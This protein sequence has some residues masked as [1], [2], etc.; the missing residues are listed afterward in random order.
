VAL[1]RWKDLCID[2][3]DAGVLAVFWG[4]VLG[5]RA[6]RQESGDFVLLGDAPEQTVWVNRVPEPKSVKNRVHLDLV[7][8]D[9]SS[10]LD[11]GAVELQRVQH[12]PHRWTVLADPEGGEFCVFDGSQGEPSALVVDSPQPVE[13]ARWWAE[14]LDAHLTPGPEGSLRWLADVAGLP[15][16]VVKF[17]G[18][19]DP[20]RVKNRVHWDVTCG[21]VEALVARGARVLREPDDEVAWH[22]LADPDGNEFCAFA[23]PTG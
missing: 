20:R 13:S 5:L 2:A 18:V 21:D 6:Q 9:V 16:G 4:S 22:V 8:P 1:A 19:P 17:V 11:L 3:S 15:F 14:V 10:L 7:R 23:P 12:S